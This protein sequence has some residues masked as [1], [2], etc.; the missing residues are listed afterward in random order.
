LE[1]VSPHAIASS[2]LARGAFTGCSRLATYAMPMKMVRGILAAFIG[3]AT[4]SAAHAGAALPD[5]Q[6]RGEQEQLLR[7]RQEG[8]ILP[9]REI[10]RRIVPMMRG[11]QYIG[12]DF[13]SDA[14]IYTLK[15]LRDGAVLWVVVD[16]RSGQ[17]LRRTGR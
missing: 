15:F 16:G 1:E 7:Q 8:R 3:T 2:A 5:P 13:D 12:F 6:H 14:A 11:A 10:E 17:I 9:V 4:M